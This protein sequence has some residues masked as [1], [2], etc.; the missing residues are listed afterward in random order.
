M[1]SMQEMENPRM[2]WHSHFASYLNVFEMSNHQPEGIETHIALFDRMFH[3]KV[4]KCLRAVQD[5]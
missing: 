3:R 1:E 5:K 4:A 2:Q